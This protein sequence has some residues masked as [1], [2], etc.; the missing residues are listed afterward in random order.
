MRSYL[1]V[2]VLS[3][4]LIATNAFAQTNQPRS[5]AAQAVAPSPTSGNMPSGFKGGKIFVDTKLQKANEAMNQEV[6]RLMREGKLE[7]TV[8]TQP[9]KALVG[10]V[11]VSEKTKERDL[12]EFNRLSQ[13]LAN[14]SASSL[15][16]QKRVEKQDAKKQPEAPDPITNLSPS[17]R[18]SGNDDTA[19]MAEL[20]DGQ[21]VV[22]R[23]NGSVMIMNER[24]RAILP[25]DGVLTLKDG[26]TFNIKD[27]MRTE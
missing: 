22:F 27:G 20:N 6:M 13:D 19:I 18:K 5:G 12:K 14:A 3:V 8:V 17:M 2:L 7:G 25:P 4:S 24:G 21:H 15:Q 16:E 10:Q 11:N 9:S 1:S 23:N 26:T